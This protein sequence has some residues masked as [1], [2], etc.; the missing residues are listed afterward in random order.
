MVPC[1]GED[2]RLRYNTP[3]QITTRD[4][5]LGVTEMEGHKYLQFKRF[6]PHE[7]RCDIRYA[8]WAFQSPE[9]SVEHEEIRHA[10]TVRL[11]YQPS[12]MYQ[13]HPGVGD[14]RVRLALTTDQ[15]INALQAL[16]GHKDEVADVR[17]ILS[18][19][20]GKKRDELFLEL[21]YAHP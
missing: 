1:P 20:Q 4:M 5:Y 7:N 6:G 11:V 17:F 14:S 18:D 19:D 10:S 13:N 16:E 21:C 9:D 12:G 3:Y 15:G 8:M 2:R